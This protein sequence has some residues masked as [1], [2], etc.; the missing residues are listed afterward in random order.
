MKRNQSMLH[1]VCIALFF[2]TGC[3]C[4]WFA[5]R[6]GIWDYTVDSFK[7]DSSIQSDVLELLALTFKLFPLAS[8]TPD[9]TNISNIS[10]LVSSAFV[11]NNKKTTAVGQIWSPHYNRIWYQ[12]VW[13]SVVHPHMV[14]NSKYIKFCLIHCTIRLL[15][16]PFFHQL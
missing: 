10:N 8:P 11:V 1:E 4:F 5:G 2:I 16:L 14:T 15:K 6:F 9:T 3:K 7:V 13:C 12:Y